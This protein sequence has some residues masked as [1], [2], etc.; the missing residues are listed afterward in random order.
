MVAR[1]GVYAMVARGGVYAMVARG[2][3]YAM[4]ARGGV[5]AMVARGGIC[6][7]SKMNGDSNISRL[8]ARHL[9]HATHYTL[10]SCFT[11]QG[12]D[13]SSYVEHL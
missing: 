13:K 3:V 7:R 5:Y 11:H 4:V 6:F 8:T 1:G 12:L 2:G 9:L 10:Y